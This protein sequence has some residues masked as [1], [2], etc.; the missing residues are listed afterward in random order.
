MKKLA[1][2]VLV[3]MM[4]FVLGSGIAVAKKGN[5]GHQI[6]P[7]EFYGQVSSTTTGAAALVFTVTGLKVASECVVSA[8]A[9]GTGPAYIKKAVVTLNTITVTVDANQTAGTTTINYICFK[10]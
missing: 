1:Y 4:T 7:V 6:M 8:K 5:G 9:L 10:P 2:L 3:S